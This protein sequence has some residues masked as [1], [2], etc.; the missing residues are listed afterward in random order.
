[1]SSPE[2]K[3]SENLN[4]NL[5]EA[6]RKQ[7]LHL[8]KKLLSD[9]AQADF[10]YDKEGTWGAREKYSPIHC[11]I[12]GLP[13]SA[14]IK[15]QEDWK[16]LIQTLLKNGTNPNETKVDQDWRGC[17][18]ENTAIELWFSRMPLPDVDL[19]SSFLESGLDPN[20]SQ[21]QTIATM[22]T[23]GFIQT[24]L[25]HNVAKLGLVDCAIALLNA[26]AEVDIRGTESTHNERG[27]AE[28]K[29]ETALHVATVHGQLEIC[30][31]LLAKGADIN[32]IESHLDARFLKKISKKNK[33]DDSRSKDY[34]NPWK[35]TPIE[36]TAIHLAIKNKHFDLARF[37]LVCGADSSIP[38]KHGQTELKSTLDYCKSEKCDSKTLLAELDNGV[39]MGKS[40]KTLSSEVQEKIL[41]TFEHIQVQSWSLNNH[42]FPDIQRILK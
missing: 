26:G 34:L 8:V 38:Y 18:S 32:A 3:L 22:R 29:S 15:Q 40:L 27:H 25:L 9:G 4:G 13:I 31:L 42:S 20:L 36:C 37:L 19:L 16:E 23:D 21:S 17:C 14:T 39:D 35:L 41:K 11:A 2:K 7:D 10:V 6:C 12:L 30:I 28:E 1:M 5:I 33:T 24:C